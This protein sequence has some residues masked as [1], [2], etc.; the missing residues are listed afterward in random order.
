MESPPTYAAEPLRNEWLTAL[1]LLLATSLLLMV[2]Y[3]QF[4]WPGSWIGSAEPLSW[5]G[6]VLNLTKGQGYTGRGVLTIEALTEQGEQS[7]AVASLSPKA[8]R[9]KDYSSVNWVTADVPPGAQLIFLWHTAENSRRIFARPLISTKNGMASLELAGDID[10][11]G[12]IMGVALL[13]KGQLDAPITIHSVSL[14]PA[15]AGVALTRL[16]DRWFVPEA[17]QGTSI[18]FL[19]ADAIGQEVPVVLAIAALVLLSLAAYLI[20]AKTR[21]LRAHVA[22]AWCIVFLGWMMLDI[23][24]QW[25]LFRQ[26]DSTSRQYAG[27]SLEEKHRAADDGLF[28][29][30]QQVNEKLPSSG[31]RVLYFSDDAYSRGKGAYYLYPHNVMAS[32]DASAIAQLKTGDF[33]VIFEKQGMKYDASRRSLVWNGIQPLAADLLMSASGNLL[34][35]VH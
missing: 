28:D 32:N 11:H 31:G 15:S 2:I 21:I 7:A 34:L 23:R 12:Q 35:R 13:V 8:F 25:N 30:M 17:W 3:L 5:K 27:K 9:A 20:L 1:L 4:F 18:N 24:W 14:K 10:W 19:D 16:T 33:V 22:I 6:S 26:L 29:F